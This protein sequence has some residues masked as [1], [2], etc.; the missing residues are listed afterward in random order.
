M[1]LSR[2]AFGDRVKAFY[3]L[4]DLPSPLKSASV[5]ETVSETAFSPFPLLQP[6]V[7]CKMEML[8]GYCVRVK[9]GEESKCRDTVQSVLSSQTPD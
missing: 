3:S 9:G 4:S 5:D 8:V 6:F 7:T 2:M 1:L